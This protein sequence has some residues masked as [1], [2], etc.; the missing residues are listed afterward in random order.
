MTAEPLRLSGL[1]TAL[2]T[3]FNADGSLDE[4]AVTELARRQVDE[5][6]S[7]LVPGGTTGEGV[8]LSFKEKIGNAL[9]V[10]E[11]A[12][13]RVPVVAG[14]GGNDTGEVVKL[15]KE[16]EQVGAAALLTVT[17]FYNKPTP[18]GLFRHYAAVAEAAGLPIVV[19]NVPGRTGVNVTPETLARLREIPQVTA[20]KEASGD[21]VQIGRIC[22]E[23]PE[24]FDVLAGD[25]S[26][27]LP[28]M[29]LG[30]AGLISVAGNLIP[31]SMATICNTCQVG[32]YQAAR[33]VH[34]RW[35]PLMEVLFCESNPGPAKFAM[36]EMGLLDAVY[37]LPMVPITGESEERVRSV[38]E[39]LEL[40]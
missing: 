34:Q 20:V 3:P 26:G 16:L 13:G 10:V 5:G 15:A 35:L 38:L 31:R 14:C 2:V 28:A 24:D 33:A 12:E 18:E 37:R 9:L 25:D 30:A 21:I 1:G 39:E 36:A 19:Y 7:F 11:A 8:T 23:A 40:I 32:E 27:A 6:A 17:P 22:A 29:A 4:H